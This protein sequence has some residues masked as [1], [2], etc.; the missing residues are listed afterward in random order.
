MTALH[1]AVLDTI[2]RQIVDGH[3][4]EGDV[5]TLD[6]IQEHFGVSRTVARET[7]RI[8]E[9]TGL[10]T[11]RR[12][13]GIIVQPQTSWNVFDPRVIWWRLSG[14][15][16]NAQL[17]TLTELRTSIEPVAVNAAA[18]NAS[19]EQ[20]ERIHTLATAMREQGE[21]GN[22]DEFLELDIAFHTL[23][24]NAS[25]NEMF[26]ALGDVVTVVLRGRVQLGFMPQHPVPLSLELHERVAQA[27]S[28]GHGEAAEAAMREILVEVRSAMAALFDN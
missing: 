13:V 18:R 2:G 19:A 12:R 5:L 22:L 11:S 8:L 4:G 10:V 3:F 25:D 17:R 7:M 9:W 26:S 28:S 1:S 14:H 24:L 23:L 21:A 20:R 16:R 15:G 6:W 27:V